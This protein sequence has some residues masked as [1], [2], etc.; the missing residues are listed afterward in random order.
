MEWTTLEKIGLTH[1]EIKTYLALL[2]LGP[3]STGPI[4]KRSGVSRSKVY[5][6]LDKLEKK[7]L[8]SH[9]EKSGV[10]YFQAVEPGKIKDYLKERK[11]ELETLEQEFEKFLPQ[12][13]AFHRQQGAVNNITVY[14]GMKGL[15]VAHEHTYLKLKRGEEYYVLG[16]PQYQPWEHLRYWEKD[17]RRRDG[18]GIKCKLLF[19]S[20][21]ERKLLENRNSYRLCEARYMPTDIKTPAYFTIYKDTTLITIPS[22]EPI[23]IEIV[24]R[25]ITDSFKA[26]FDEFWNRSKPFL[27]RES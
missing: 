6:I 5:A 22:A 10:V 15:K 27:H 26:Y 3:S 16:V 20:D 4:A 1:G 2:K 23:S 19:N 8:A 14:Q 7:G 13:E 12:L 18:A 17:H 24:S 11:E 9:I 21:S 25:E